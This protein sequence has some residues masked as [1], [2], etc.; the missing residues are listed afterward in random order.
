MW[1]CGMKMFSDQ[2]RYNSN[3]FPLYDS[4]ESNLMTPTS[5]IAKKLK[6]A[7]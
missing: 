4:N 6:C 2:I 5:L 7:N 1:T 3:C